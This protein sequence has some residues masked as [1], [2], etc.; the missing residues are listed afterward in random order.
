MSRIE[1]L[2]QLAN[3]SDYI[4]H[5]LTVKH[6]MFY[7]SD[8]I[9]TADVIVD[10]FVNPPTPYAQLHTELFRMFGP[11]TSPLSYKRTWWKTPEG[12]PLEE[13][14]L[15]AV[16]DLELRAFLMNRFNAELYDLAELTFPKATVLR[17]W[18][19]KLLGK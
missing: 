14:E 8:L 1:R 3:R 17:S 10:Q 9:V 18:W 5:S 19:R 2:Q 16:L 7:A 11:C 4:V 12:K 13:G 6:E 15:S